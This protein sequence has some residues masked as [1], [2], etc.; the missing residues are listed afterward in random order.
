MDKKE[1]AE[2]KAKMP[3]NVPQIKPGA[4]V[5]HIVSAIDFSEKNYLEFKLDFAEGAYANKIYKAVGGNL[6]QWW[7]MMVKRSYYGGGNNARFKGDITAIERSN[8]GYLFEEHNFDERTLVGK[9]VVVVLREEEYMKPDGSV[10]SAL[11]IDSFRS[12]EAFRNGEIQTPPKLTIADQLRIKQER[13]AN[14]Q[15]GMSTY[16]P[17]AIPTFNPTTNIATPSPFTDIEI[18]DSDLPF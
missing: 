2:T 10:A 7:N 1:W 9:Y 8:Q 3:G 18:D 6:F 4:Y 13:E 14:A 16:E 17:N 11:K 12:I 5:C 15:K